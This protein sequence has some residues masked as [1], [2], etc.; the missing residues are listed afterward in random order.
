MK[1]SI[2]LYQIGNN[3]AFLYFVR[4]NIFIFRKQLSGE[5]KN[6]KCFV[7]NEKRRKAES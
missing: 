1:Y 7:Q 5:R 6:L 2:N 3:S 4:M